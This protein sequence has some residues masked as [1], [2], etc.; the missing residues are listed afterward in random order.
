MII[1]Y[2]LHK[3]NHND[4]SYSYKVK[5]DEDIL[6]VD[7]NLSDYPKYIFID[8]SYNDYNF[9]YK[10]IK[11]YKKNINKNLGDIK[12]IDTS[13]YVK[14]RTGTKEIIF[15]NCLYKKCN[16]TDI[17]K[18]FYLYNIQNDNCKLYEY[19][20]KNVIA[21]YKDKREKE[22]ELNKKNMKIRTFR[23]NNK[24]YNEITI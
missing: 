11:F 19:I 2:V 20:Y 16:Q 17:D 21:F 24:I 7:V 18:Y 13:N 12:L 22:I 5:I 14:N 23:V 9:Y 4:N 15:E 1:N 6:L 3:F 10:I 8:N